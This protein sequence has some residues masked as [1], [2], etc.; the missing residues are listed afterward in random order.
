MSRSLLPTT[1]LHLYNRWMTD[2]SILKINHPILQV[3]ST[4]Q[5]NGWRSVTIDVDTDNIA[6]SLTRD[7]M[8]IPHPGPEYPPVVV[9]VRA[10]DTTHMFTMLPNR[11]P[12]VKL[13]EAIMRSAESPSRRSSRR[14]SLT[15]TVGDLLLCCFHSFL[16]TDLKQEHGEELRFWSA[17]R[18]EE[19]YRQEGI[20]AYAHMVCIEIWGIICTCGGAQWRKVLPIL[21]RF[22]GFG[23]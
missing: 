19:I 9:V 15:L 3:T 11:H 23:S 7:L 18:R 21:K 12:V 13:F 2:A 6:Q 4:C 5:I 8:K 1:D 14:S 16:P 10:H 20:P 22:P 17:M